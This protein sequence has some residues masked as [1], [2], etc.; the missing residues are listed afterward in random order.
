MQGIPAMTNVAGLSQRMTDFVMTLRQD[1]DEIYRRLYDA[2]DDR[3]LMSGQLNMLCRDRRSHAR[4]ARL[5]ESEARLSHE[6]WMVVLQR[7]QT[8]AREPARSEI[9]EEADNSL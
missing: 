4:T 1:T 5:M 2:Q 9:P 3:S 8:P 6:A 7:Q